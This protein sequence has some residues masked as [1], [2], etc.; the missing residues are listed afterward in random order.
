MANKTV[1][2]KICGL[3]NL[4]DAVAALEYGANYLGFVFYAKS[5]RYVAPAKV[6]KILGKLNSGVKAIG[7]FVN[8][9]RADVEAV[10]SDCGLYTIQLHG[11]ESADDFSDMPLPV[12]RAIK[13]ERK[14]VK[15][16]PG[17]WTAARYLVDA[18][19]PG[20]YGG[21]GAVADWQ[22]ARKLAIKHPIMLAGGLTP[23][24]VAAA[25]A[26]VHPLGVD[27]VSGVEAEPGKKDIKKLEQFI[28]AA[29]SQP[30]LTLR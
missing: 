19:V 27:V 30:F 21:T 6:I 12:W 22:V 7:V 18:A 20:Q 25:I 4:K 13:I 26:A 24:N 16:S 11:D 3:T 28:H 14:L 23:E 8:M 29:K 2:V 10:A 15:P 9:P 1:E 17:K 5:P